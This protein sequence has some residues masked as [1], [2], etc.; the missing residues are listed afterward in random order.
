MQSNKAIVGV[1][2]FAHESGIH[3]DGVL[4]QRDTYEIMRAEDV[5]WESNR[6]CLGK[7]SGRRAFKD[8]MKGLGYELDRKE[9]DVAFTKFKQLADSQREIRDAQLV[10]LVSSG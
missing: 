7:L 9:L 10:E 3:Q 1:N 8:H 6:I 2:A 4:K 5:G